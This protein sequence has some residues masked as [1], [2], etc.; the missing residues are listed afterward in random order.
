MYHFDS[1]SLWSRGL[2]AEGRDICFFSVVELRSGRDRG[3]LRN[4]NS[5]PNRPVVGSCQIPWQAR[6]VGPGTR[7]VITKRGEGIDEGGEFDNDHTKNCSLKNP[8]VNN[9]AGK[10]S[11]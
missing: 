10:L 2:G 8:T 6:E 4:E 11:N 7:L 5:D 1:S 9:R 3:R